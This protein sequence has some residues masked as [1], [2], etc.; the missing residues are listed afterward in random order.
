MNRM[1]EH[2]LKDCFIVFEYYKIKIQSLYSELSKKGNNHTVDTQ[3]QYS[4][5]V[6]LLKKI[7]YY[8]HKAYKLQNDINKDI[9]KNDKNLD[10]YFLRNF[11]Q[12]TN[13]FE[14]IHNHIIT[15]FN[16]QIDSEELNIDYEFIVR[17]H[18]KVETIN[19]E[20]D[21]LQIEFN[22]SMV[23]DFDEEDDME[24]KQSM[25]NFVKIW[26]KFKSKMMS[27]QGTNS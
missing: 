2:V 4:D 22:E 7:I 9:I 3:D 18:T 1:D 24:M 16:I 17:N 5:R 15:E 12:Y 6:N 27:T 19:N 10:G 20:D 11:T 8:F 25:E 26:E 13:Y 14:V 21:V 23:I